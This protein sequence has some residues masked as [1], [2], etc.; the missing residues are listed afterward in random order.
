LVSSFAR[1]NCCSSVIYRIKNGK[2]KNYKT[3]QKLKKKLLLF[4][5]ILLSDPLQRLIL[6]SEENFP[7]NEIFWV[8]IKSLSPLDL[9]STGVDELVDRG[10]LGRRDNRLR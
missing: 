5:N 7:S 6:L 9:R 2:D 4:P 1:N 10:S 8:G 3:K